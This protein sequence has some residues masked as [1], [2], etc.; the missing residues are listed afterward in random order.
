MLCCLLRL[1]L[2][3]FGVLCLA[4]CLLLA[5]FASFGGQKLWD[6]LIQAMAATPFQTGMVEEMG[7]LEGPEDDIV[8]EELTVSIQ[9]MYF[10]DAF[11]PQLSTLLA[12]YFSTG[13][14]LM[15]EQ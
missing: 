4:F 3:G 2:L 9:P 13:Q 8:V 5:G 12:L 6:L 15:L 14:A 10:G 1:A 11:V 7:E